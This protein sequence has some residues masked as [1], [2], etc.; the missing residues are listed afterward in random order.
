MD[1]ERLFSNAASLDEGR[2]VVQCPVKQKG[3]LLVALTSPIC[4]VEKLSF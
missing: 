2:I 3:G 4:L 1:F